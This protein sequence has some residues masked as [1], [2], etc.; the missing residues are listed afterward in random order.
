MNSDEKL[1]PMC[2]EAIKTVAVKCKHCH[3]ILDASSEPTT[4]VKEYYYYRYGSGK[5]EGPFSYDEIKNLY[6]NEKIS[7][8]VFISKNETNDWDVITSYLIHGGDEKIKNLKDQSESNR[9]WLLLIVAILISSAIIKFVFFSALEKDV[10]K[11]IKQSHTQTV[12][13]TIIKI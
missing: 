10:T 4:K 9:N 8:S 13:E 1:C 12:K 11:I 5:K 7:S 3:S 6:Q 2:G